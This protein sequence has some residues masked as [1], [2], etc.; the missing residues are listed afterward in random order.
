MEMKFDHKP[1]VAGRKLNV[2]PENP[3]TSSEDAVVE[4][5]RFPKWL[6]RKLPSSNTLWQTQNILDKHRLPTVCEEAKCPNLTECWSKNTATFL[7]MGSSC[8][9][10]C[11]FCDIDFAAKP[12]PLELDEPKRLAE[13]ARTLGLKHVVITMVAR[14]DLSDGGASHIASIIQA[15][16]EENK[17]VEVLTSDF[18]GNEEALKTVLDAK[19]E[20]FNHNIETVRRLTPRVRHKATY[21]RTLEVLTFA[22][23]NSNCIIKSGLMVGLGESDLE[24][25]QTIDDLHHAG[26]GIITIGHYLQ[27]NRHKL[28]IKSFITP[29]QFDAYAAYGKKIG[30]AQMHSGPFVRS[31]YNA[32]EL[33]EELR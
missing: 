14:D 24:V 17:T 27:A 8:T 30:V 32:A 6:H 10:A 3:D 4:L 7:A 9:R 33:F 15:L 28:R 2:L 29:K 25:E 22:K 23:K 20:I 1:K 19:P 5:G 13:S 26:C 16:H 31:S 21:E 12:K 11:G 18:Q